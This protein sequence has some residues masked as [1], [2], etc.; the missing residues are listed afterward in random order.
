MLNVTL[1]A[2]GFYILA[3]FFFFFFLRAS[4]L[5]ARLWNQVPT[6]LAL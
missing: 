1:L 4:V 3:L 6:G 2:Q 5:G